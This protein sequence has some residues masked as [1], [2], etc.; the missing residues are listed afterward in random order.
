M[1]R[2]YM[3]HAATTPVDGSVLQEML[4][5]FREKFGNAS[6]IHQYGQEAK[7][8]LEESRE[9]IAQ[10]LGAKPSELV[11]VSGGTEADNWAIRGVAYA[12]KQKGNHIITSLAEHHAVIHAC[13]ALE[14]EGFKVTYL[15]P[16]RYGQIHP[17]Q[18][19]EA[20]TKKTVLI[21]LMHV[22]NELGTINPIAA[23][24]KVAR[25][26]GI[27]FH[28]DAVQSF[29]KIRYSVDEL[30]VDL[31]TLSAHKIYGPKG[32]GALYIREGTPIVPLLYGGGH[33]RNL[34][35]GTQNVPAIVG[36][37][38]AV[39]IG[40]RVLEEEHE[41]IRSLREQFLSGLKEQVADFRV[42]GHPA[43]HVPGILN[44]SF[45]GVDAESLLISL[46]MKGI[47]VSTGSACS[48][49]SAQP[50]HVLR[51]IGLEDEYLKCTLRFSMGRTNT[52]EDIQYTVSA[53]AEIIERLR[54]MSPAGAG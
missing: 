26:Y 29:C 36:F 12:L 14:K 21:T 44:I 8:A 35:A 15:K 49:G 11:F 30:N 42:N 33:E 5:Y 50:S 7:A 20:I 38:R 25:K 27:V 6:S 39:E 17:E 2:I 46:D 16:D 51:A 47:A 9:K 28:T 31:M 41:R 1:R 48:S 52:E 37:A 24:G 19:E 45:A 40:D 54:A 13:E 22:N 4:P 3:D 53:L 43:E 23:I 10:F 32:V 34:R 18:V